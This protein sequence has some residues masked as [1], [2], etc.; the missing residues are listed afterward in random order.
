MKIFLPPFISGLLFLL[1]TRAEA[2]AGPLRHPRFGMPEGDRIEVVDFS[3]SPLQ[4][5]EGDTVTVKILFR[6][7]GTAVVKK[8]DWRILRNEEVLGIGAVE[9]IPA[10]KRFYVT[11]TWTATVGRQQFSGDVDFDNLLG[12]NEADRKNNLK[13][14]EVTVGSRSVTIVAAPLDPRRAERAGAHFAVRLDDSLNSG[15]SSSGL[16]IAPGGPAGATLSLRVRCVP[17]GGRILLE[18]FSEFRLQNGWKIKEI[19]EKV[20][21]AEPA[22]RWHWIR[23]PEKGSD[24]PW[25]QLEI[26]SLGAEGEVA[27]SVLIEGPEHR[28]PY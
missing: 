3:I 24:D 21:L 7:V 5:R 15:C 23:R 2:A 9:N 27:I 6:N 16:V 17:P 1:C 19:S 26:E 10:G 18:A 4:P 11:T 14:L 22:A 13:A 12:E 25:M 20:T 28:E 8:L